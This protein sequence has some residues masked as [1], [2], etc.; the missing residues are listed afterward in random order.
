MR[1]D[2]H[3]HVAAHGEFSY[4]Q[5]WIDQYIERAHQMGI[6]EIGFSEH[7]E[8]SHLVD[9]NLFKHV[10]AEK[11]YDINVRLGLEVDY[12]PG[13]EEKIKQ[14]VSQTEYDYTI[15]S[16]HFI[17]GW[18]FDHPD[19]RTG[20]SERDIDD[21]YAQYA[22]LLLRMGQSACFDIVGHIDLVKIWGHRPCKHTA[23]HYFD[24]VLKAIQKHGLAVEIN[25]A[26]LRKE[27]AE[28]YPA[29]DI[30]ARMFSYDIPITFGSDAHRP[31][32]IGEGLEVAYQAARQA[33]YRYLVRFNRHQ[34]IITPLEY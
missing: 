25:S 15:G 6:Q 12:I 31:E 21:V 26:G 18:G 7:D 10:Q 30:V 9:I 32:Q 22:A 34:Q 29:A 8:F 27:V 11:R 2:Y 19:F 23:L 16:V 20:F 1:V 17:E 4:S 33:G 13:R 5:E 3:V 14:I 28:L 24:P